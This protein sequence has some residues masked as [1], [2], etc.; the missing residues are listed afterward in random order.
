MSAGAESRTKCFWSGVG[1]V[2]GTLRTGRPRRLGGRCSSPG[3]IGGA[4]DRGPGPRARDR[5]ARSR[6]RPDRRP[7]RHA[8]AGRGPASPAPS[9]RRPWTESIAGRRMPGRHAV[10]YPPGVTL[11]TLRRAA[12]ASPVAIALLIVANLVPLVGVLFFGW[13]LTT[14]VALYWLENGV[15]GAFALARMA[16]AEG[17][18][19]DPGS[20]DDQRP[21]AVR[22]GAPQPGHGPRRP[23]A[24][25]RPPLR[26]VLARPRRV[27]VVRPADGLGADGRAR[28]RGPSLVACLW[29][30][31]VLVLSHGAS[32]VYNWWLG[33][34][35]YTSSPS[36]E[37]GAPY[38]RVV[39]LHVTIVLGRVPRRVPRLADLGAGRCWSA[40]RPSPTS[41]PT[42]PSGGARASVPGPRAWRLPDA[43]PHRLVLAGPRRSSGSSGERLRVRLVLEDGCRLRRP[44]GGHPRGQRR[45]RRARGSAPPAAPRCP[46]CRWRPWRPGCRAAS[47]RSTAAS[48][49]RPGAGWGSGRR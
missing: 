25:L 49:A 46:R 43:R 38:G 44:V 30:L 10:R 35:R 21:A 40:S 15:V 6:R 45:R 22:R 19:E 37:M 34:E 24:V 41:R 42:S 17:V 27:R 14:I 4:A 2:S 20:R 8:P 13:S 28:P 36:R 32:F 33:G 39:V 7:V 12:H 3:R 29:A 26:D 18:D 1:F 11:M 16:T 9:A 5:A 31:P 48:P 47:G 23:D